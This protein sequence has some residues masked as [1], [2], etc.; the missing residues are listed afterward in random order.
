MRGAVL[1]C[2]LC[3]PVLAAEAPV[4]ILST[5]AVQGAFADIDSLLRA[6]GGVPFTIEFAATIP[7]VERL[8]GGESA[9]LV[10]LTQEG[11]QQL[12]DKGRVQMRKDLVLSQVGI[13]VADDA[14]LPILKTMDDFV[15]LL[16]STPSIAYT[17]RGASGLHMAKVIEDLGLT[18]LVHPKVTLVPEGFTGTLLLK[19]EVAVAVQQLSE[20]KL[21]GATNIVPLPDAIQSRTIFTTAILSGTPRAEAAAKIVAI[22]ASP[23]AAKAYVRSGVEPVFE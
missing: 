14:P 18:E 22:L 19:G 10:I 8:L 15:A 6:H 11:V 12:A 4:R 23:D 1:C 20:L 16:K 7:A 2:L 21:A 17:A 3:A 5:L 13:A 9:D